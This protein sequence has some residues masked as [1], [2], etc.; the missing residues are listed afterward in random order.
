MLNT[1]VALTALSPLDG[2]YTSQLTDLANLFSEFALIKQR[3]HVEISYL[4]FMSEVGCFPALTEAQKKQLLGISTRFSLTDA[5]AVK[6]IEK[7]T[8]HDVKAV[9]YFVRQK[10]TELE[11]PLVEYVHLALTS[12]DVNSLAYSLMIQDCQ[13]NVLVPRLRALLRQLSDLAE[14][15]S[16]TPMLARTHGQEAVPTTV[17]KELAVFAIRL[18]TELEELE[19]IQIEAKLTGAVGN[20]NAHVVAFPKQ[21]WFVLSD[22]FVSSFDLKPSLDTTQILPT[23]S[24]S[25]LFS[26]LV[27]INSILLDLNQDI[28]RY[29]S[30]H[31]FGQKVAE[32]QVGSS[33][34]PQKVNPIDFENSEGNLGLANSLLMFFIQKLPISRLQRD[35]SDSTVKRSIGTAFGYCHLAYTSLQKGLQKIT[36]NEPKL[37]ADLDSHWEVLA[38]AFQV[39]LRVEG[40]EAGYEKLKTFSQ[41]KQLAKADIT[42]FVESLSI[43]AAGKQKLL[44][45]TPHTYLGLAPQITHRAVQRINRY[46]KGEL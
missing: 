44:Q 34:M 14:S 25:R 11:L 45:L 7:N 32:G 4:I 29:I 12:E 2:R 24:Y 43:S 21:D 46:L 16:T 13:R 17:G 42:A 30:D 18:L 8:H 6:E 5:E 23:E 3:V 36:V 26:N 39:I 1:H 37:K 40:D 27:R 15:S 41:G 22:Q 10:L 35:L 19:G 28:W 33:T 31:A 38:E 9:E 20:F